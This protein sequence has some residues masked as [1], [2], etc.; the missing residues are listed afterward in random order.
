MA[1]KLNESLRH[2]P[3]SAFTEAPVLQS[4]RKPLA[5]VKQRL[6]SKGRATI[7]AGP[8]ASRPTRR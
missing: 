7:P 6:L 3:G 5:K 2:H 4:L 1:R 8:R